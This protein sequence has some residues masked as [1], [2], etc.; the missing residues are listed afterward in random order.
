VQNLD[1]GRT[2]ILVIIFTIIRNSIFAMDKNITLA[3]N[4]DKII[5]DIGLNNSY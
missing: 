4:A 1:L 3:R 2:L 5:V